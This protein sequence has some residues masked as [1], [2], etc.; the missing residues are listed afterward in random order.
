MA[1]SRR[2]SS[3]GPCRAGG[4]V[5][6][7]RGHAAL[8][9]VGVLLEMGS[10]SAGHGLPRPGLRRC[11][12]AT[13]GTSPRAGGSA[14]ACPPSSRL[15]RACGGAWRAPFA[16]DASGHVAHCASGSRCPLPSGA[17]RAAWSALRPARCARGRGD[18]CDSASS[19][20]LFRQLQPIA[21][22]QGHLHP[23]YC[24]LHS[25]VLISFF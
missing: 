19:F 21:E 22:R 1:G 3:A 7:E 20:W 2:P 13:G 16:R 23:M 18:V 5:R 4:A 12:E 9:A 8:P 24:G 15:S 17:S 11:A 14:R 6:R 10:S 25:R